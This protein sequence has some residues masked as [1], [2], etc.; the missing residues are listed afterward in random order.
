MCFLSLS[1][2]VWFRVQPEIF[3]PTRKEC[4]AVFLNY[5]SYF[6]H[7]DAVVLSAM[8]YDTVYRSTVL[9]LFQALL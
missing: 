5:S 6:S 2:T 9:C 1:G 7:T 8:S 4:D 3:T